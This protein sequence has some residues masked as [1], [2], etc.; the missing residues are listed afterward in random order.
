[1]RLTNL[2]DELR[3][4]HPWMTVIEV[5]DVRDGRI[6]V[7]DTWKRL[8]DE[9]AGSGPL[10]VTWHH[11]ASGGAW[12]AIVDYEFHKYWPKPGNNANVNEFG[13]VA[14]MASGSTATNGAGTLR[15]FSRGMGGRNSDQYTI[16][17]H[18]PGNGSKPY[19]EAQLRTCF[20]LNNTVNRL[21]GNQPTDLMTH[22][23]WAPDR[24]TDPA[25]AHAV[26]GLWRPRAANGSGTWH[27]DDI[28]AEARR[29]AGSSTVIPAEGEDML[30][31]TSWGPGRYHQFAI[32][33]DKQLWYRF[34]E[35][36][37][38]ASWTEW[39]PLGGLYTGNLTAI[40]NAVGRIDVFATGL[41]NHVWQTAYAND[42]W[43]WRDL[44]A[45]P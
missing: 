27:G 19:T 32:G 20:A 24:K 35:E 43:S 7:G 11:D 17:I 10:G 22:H 23:E 34:Y 15:R 25:P 41:D 1:M 9:Y 3:R 21:S 2:A 40:A 38:G 18:N 44:G 12:V 14:L 31:V 45:M 39:R 36:A 42:A 33:S 13:H 37:D 30:A 6:I 16:E 26:Q 5:G 29:R 8:G 28:R 4:E